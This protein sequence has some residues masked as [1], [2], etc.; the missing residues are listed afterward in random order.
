M[1]DADRLDELASAVADGRTIEWSSADASAGL[2]DLDAIAE[3]RIIAEI[4]R[5]HRESQDP[6]ETAQLPAP[7]E[8]SGASPPPQPLFRWGSLHVSERLGSGSFGEVYRAWDSALDREVALKLLRSVRLRAPKATDSIIREGQLLARVRHPNVMAVYGAQ[9]IDGRVGIWGELLRGRTLADIVRNDGPLSAQEASLFGDAICRALTAVHRAG[10]LHR[11]IKAQNVMRESG[12]RIVLMDFGLGRESDMPGAIEGLELAGTPLY[13]APELFEGEPASAQS[14]I[15]SVGVLLFYLVTGS[16]PVGG[17]SIDEVGRQ[18]KARKAA[19]L[20]DL[21]S[22]LPAAFV[23]V[24][25]RALS[26]DRES[27]FESAGALQAGLSV[28]SSAPVPQGDKTRTRVRRTVATVGAMVVVLLAGAASSY[29]LR[30]HP[31]GEISTIRSIA[32]LE[33]HSVSNEPSETYLASAVPLELNTAL[34]RIGPIKTIPWS[35]IN[36]FKKGGQPLQELAQRTGADAALEGSVQLIPPVSAGGQKR[37]RIG[38][39]LYSTRTG[40]LLWSTTASS[41]LGE[42]IRLTDTLTDRVARQIEVKLALRDEMRP[43]SSRSVTDEAMELYLRGRDLLVTND[44]A[45]HLSDARRDFE[46]ATA[47]EKRFA[48]AYSGLA[49]CEIVLATYW[50]VSEPAEAYAAALEATTRAIQIDPG[51]AAAWA[52]RAYAHF[53]LGWDWAAADDDFRRALALDPESDLL[54]TWYEDYLSAIGRDAEAVTLAKAAAARFP[55]SAHLQRRVAWAAFFNRDYDESI[56]RLKVALQLEPSYISARTLLGRSYLQKA[57]F[58]EGIAELEGVVA[59]SKDSSFACMLA[60]AYAAAGRRNDALALLQQALSNHQPGVHIF[61]YEVALVYAG[62]GEQSE[63]L[64][65]LERGYDQKDVTM[66][67]LKHDPRFDTL[68]GTPR[69]Q[70]LV[71]KMGFPR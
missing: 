35:F 15:Y 29:Y 70:A 20:Q 26:P 24:V 17:G 55:Q 36:Q 60:H 28:I 1:A 50:G 30:L 68:R 31:S 7:A 56:R 21:R 16:F 14:D 57:L 2:G 64:E 38:L 37:V 13:L 9:H 42:L 46:L 63:A 59:G 53:I 44:S 18:H 51:L 40:S 41:E 25:E 34:A 23:Q 39:E 67:N 19:R 22:D 62:L 43:H 65:W 69:F 47:R 12:G 45:T 66:V 10:L 4:A 54:H 3:L 8:P 11:D 61:P 58:K 49:D 5:L 48:E 52:S 32:V 71:E 27:R 6:L 33:F